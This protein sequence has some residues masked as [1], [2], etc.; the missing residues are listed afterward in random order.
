MRSRIAHALTLGLALVVFGGL[1]RAQTGAAGVRSEVSAAPHAWVLLPSEDA[2]E[3]VLIHVPP[4]R[5]VEGMSYEASEVGTIRVARRLLGSPIGIASWGERVY[6]LMP[7]SGAAPV[8]VL[9]LRAA[10]TGL[11][12]FWS[13]LPTDR[14]QSL[15]PLPAGFSAQR[16]VGSPSGP[17]VIGVL[18]GERVVL[19]YHAGVWSE[20]ETGPLQ[21]ADVLI[22]GRV[23]ALLRPEGEG[24]A[25][26][27]RIEGDRGE[28]SL[29]VKIPPLDRVIDARATPSRLLLAIET[30]DAVEISALHAGEPE[31]IARFEHSTG[32]CGGAFIGPDGFSYAQVCAPT[33]APAGRL[34]VIEYSTTTG[35]ELYRGPARNT[36]PISAARFRLFTLVLIGL[37]VLLLLLT[38]RTSTDAP[39]TLPEGYALA[40]P[41]RRLIAS[42]IDGLI[43]ALLV[44]LVSGVRVMDLLT[45]R[46][47]FD[48]GAS[49]LLVP[50]VLFVGFV[51]GVAGESFTGRSL[52]K[53]L[54][55]CRV[56]RAT[57]DAEPGGPRPAGL[58]RS[59]VRNL[60]KWGLPPVSVLALVE[61]SGRSRAD[62]VSGLVV[63]TELVPDQGS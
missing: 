8:R 52:G 39:L 60:I 59:L 49:W 32:A 50:A 6:L 29:R 56:I 23:L 11:A 43:A 15:E 45:L 20:L 1:A 26:V 10:P 9:T 62:V 4:R 54:T 25:S 31:R 19:R 7:R 46:V 30:G 34:E 35:D 27:V 37:T 16:I 40:E 28:A 47:L 42:L 21:E 14:L 57:S 48:S 44:S 12:D 13:Y 3:T 53:A 36:V 63:V 24:T 22:G 41:S 51:L 55:G 2:D 17:A 18:D 58:G 38:I 5:V 61:P 33:D